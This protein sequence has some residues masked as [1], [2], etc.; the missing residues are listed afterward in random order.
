MPRSARKTAN[1]PTPQLEWQG[2]IRSRYEH[3][4]TAVTRSH[5]QTSKESAPAVTTPRSP[6][7]AAASTRTQ[8]RPRPPPEHPSAPTP[9]HISDKRP[10]QFAQSPD[11]SGTCSARLVHLLEEPKWPPQ[12][13]ARAATPFAC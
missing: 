2:Q 5:L 13:L 1:R 9:F 10:D 11:P 7:T 8:D 12:R 6:K 4:A 3:F